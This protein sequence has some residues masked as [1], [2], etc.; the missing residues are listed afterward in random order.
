MLQ[1]KNSNR[2][3]PLPARCA[4]TLI[5]LL[6]VIAIIAILAA[7]L[8]PALASAKNRAIRMQCANNLRQMGVALHIY[9]DQ[10]QDKLP[11]FAAENLI[12]NF[13]VSVTDLMLNNGMTRDVMYDPGFPEQNNDVLWGGPNGFNNSGVRVTGYAET[14]GP[15]VLPNAKWT[16][17]FGLA[18]SNWNFT[19]TCPIVI[20]NPYDGTPLR[21]GP[22]QSDRVLMACATISLPGAG[23]SYQ[24]TK[25]PADWSKVSG[26]PNDL[27]STSH[28]VGTLPAGGNVVML[29]GHLE[30]HKFSLFTTAIRT[31]GILPQFWW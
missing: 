7:I 17:T 15:T 25:I 24:W 13:P 26:N 2:L 20:N 11:T 30:W 23:G 19:V 4:F 18:W 27:H 10:F 8:L 16:S 12:W 21:P 31:Q 6:V 3:H 5:E 14:F 29:D 28:M 1:E 22:T 9:A